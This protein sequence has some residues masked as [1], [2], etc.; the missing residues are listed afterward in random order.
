M[1]FDYMTKEQLI[2]EILKLHG[3]V[4]EL[5]SANNELR[6]VEN[7][8]NRRVRELGERTKEMQC[9]YG[10][11]ALLRD[12]R[13]PLPT[14]VQ[15]IVELLPRAFQYPETASVRVVVLGQEYESKGYRPTSGKMARIVTADGQKVGVL[16][17]GYREQKPPCDEGP[18]LQD[19]RTLLDAVAVWLGEIVAR[20]KP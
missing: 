16:E 4:I 9:L 8:L 11:A 18:F 12:S 3:R 2:D 7:T 1:D 17:V 5:E 19:E 20:R 13:Q 14:I 6:W 15:G 10:I